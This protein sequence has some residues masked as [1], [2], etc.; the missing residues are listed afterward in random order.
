VKLM[1]GKWLWVGAAAL[2]GVGFWWWSRKQQP[3]SGVVVDFMIPPVQV[4]EDGSGSGPWNIATTVTNQNMLMQNFIVA[5]SGSVEGYTLS[6]A[7]VQWNINLDAGSW[8][9][10]YF[11]FYIPAGVVPGMGGSITIEVRN[12]AGAK[13]VSKTHSFVVEPYYE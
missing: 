7:P 5:P 6:F 11:G 2:A 10:D 13:L 8:L 4:Y 1:K 12:Q 3:P 9:T